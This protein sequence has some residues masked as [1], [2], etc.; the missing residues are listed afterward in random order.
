LFRIG[1]NGSHSTPCSLHLHVRT[2]IHPQKIK[3]IY[4]PPPCALLNLREE[5]KRWWQKTVFCWSTIFAIV[6]GVGGL[7]PSPS[8][9]ERDIPSAHDERPSCICTTRSD[10][11]H[12]HTLDLRLI[13]PVRNEP[14]VLLLL[15]PPFVLLLC[16]HGTPLPAQSKHGL[17]RLPL[18]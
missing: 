6:A 14:N 5:V 8:T 2:A 17:V 13:Y 15:L 11:R 9:T 3:R 12:G 18:V 1:C 10:C 4:G 7:W 16:C